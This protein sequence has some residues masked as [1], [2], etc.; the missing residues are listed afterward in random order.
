M[1]CALSW[2]DSNVLLL[3]VYLCFVVDAC[4][5]PRRGVAMCATH[6]F[7]EHVFCEIAPPLQVQT[8]ERRWRTR[9][10]VRAN[11]CLSSEL[12]IVECSSFDLYSF[13]GAR[14]QK[15]ERQTVPR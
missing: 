11:V 8:L 15:S 3:C 7:S 2:F 5:F 14:A 9:L 6:I 10:L 1:L 4:K 13:A 12:Q